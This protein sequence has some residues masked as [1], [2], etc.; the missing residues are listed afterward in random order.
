[1]HIIRIIASSI[2]ALVT[3]RIAGYGERKHDALMSFF[4]PVLEGMPGYHRDALKQGR[5]RKF[6]MAFPYV[7]HPV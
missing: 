7:L 3:G 2:D 5:D 1:M 4:T 6:I